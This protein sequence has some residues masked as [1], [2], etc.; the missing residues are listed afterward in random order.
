MSVNLQFYVDMFT[1]TEEILDE[2]GHW[3][4]QVNRQRT[5]VKK[6][7][8]YF[9]KNYV[10]S[11]FPFFEKVFVI[12]NCS[13]FR[14]KVLGLFVFYLFEV[15]STVLASSYSQ[16]ENAFCI[17][18]LTWFRPQKLIAVN[19]TFLCLIENAHN[20]RTAKKV[21]HFTSF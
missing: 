16:G 17:K 8:T 21:I 20:S 19:F 15:Q 1:F 7:I 4:L 12:F 14:C 13:M 18:Y 6:K 11:L 3:F 9:L 5:V 10:T 2:K